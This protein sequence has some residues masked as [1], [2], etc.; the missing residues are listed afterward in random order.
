MPGVLVVAGVQPCH[1]ERV[2]TEDFR[3]PDWFWNQR[4]RCVYVRLGL[5]VANLSENN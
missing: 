4:S 1:L 3:L 2:L 5:R